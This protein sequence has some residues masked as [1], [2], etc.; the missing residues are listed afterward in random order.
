MVRCMSTINIKFI[1]IKID[2]GFI[3]LSNCRY[4]CAYTTINPRTT[5][6]SVIANGDSSF[7]FNKFVYTI[8][9]NFIFHISSVFYYITEDRSIERIFSL[10]FRLRF[11]FRFN[12]YLC[13]QTTLTSFFVECNIT[14]VFNKSTSS[15]T[16]CDFNI[17][18]QVAFTF[19]Y[20][21]FFVSTIN[22]CVVVQFVCQAIKYRIYLF[23]IS[24]LNASIIGSQSNNAVF[25]SRINCYITTND[26]S[27]HFLI[28]SIYN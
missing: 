9:K 18:R 4:C 8:F 2:F 6:N 25:S 3:T 5:I 15:Q 10:S 19:N 16:F 13:F 26:I 23:R 17:A 1:S 27:R 22:V 14:K 21:S 20:A 24:S 11:R 7:I 12:R 28:M